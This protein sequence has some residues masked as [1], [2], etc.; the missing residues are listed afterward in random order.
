MD[1]PVTITSRKRR[2]LYS[3]SVRERWVNR[4]LRY[5]VSMRMRIRVLWY[6]ILGAQLGRGVDLRRVD[7]PRNPWG[8]R[9]DSNSCVD[10]YS[11][12]LVSEE[13]SAGPRIIIESG[14]YINR[15]VMIDASDCIRIGTG[16][17]IGPHC[18]ITDHDHG[19]ALDRPIAQQP[20]AGAPV[21]IGR[22][23]WIGAGAIILKGVTIGD[24]A[25]VA[26][27]AVVTKDVEPGSIVGGVPARVISHRC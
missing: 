9:I 4:M 14:C 27:G 24:E 23:V 5:P 22:D 18:Y 1:R 20:L 25:V 2:T 13:K 15:F 6:R 16:T 17:M 10:D 7:I 26:A 12:L 8:V 21:Y 3:S 11:V 19:M